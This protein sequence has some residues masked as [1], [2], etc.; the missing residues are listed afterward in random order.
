M[1]D[2]LGVVSLEGD[3]GRLDGGLASSSR[4]GRECLSLGLDLLRLLLVREVGLSVTE[5]VSENL[6]GNLGSVAV[7]L[8]LVL[9][10]LVDRGRVAKRSAEDEVLERLL[11]LGRPNDILGIDIVVRVVRISSAVVAVVRVLAERVSGDGTND[12]SRV[13][14]AAK[15]KKRK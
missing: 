10:S 7:R 5:F 15:E 2:N 9:V 8:P 11:H 4:D 14:G 3:L 6:K 1:L 12:S 13:K